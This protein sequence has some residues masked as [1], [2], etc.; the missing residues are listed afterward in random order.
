MKDIARN[1]PGPSAN[2]VVVNKVLVVTIWVW[3]ARKWTWSLHL[4]IWSHKHTYDIPKDL[5]TLSHTHIHT[6]V[7]H[8]WTHIHEPHIKRFTH[9]HLQTY[10]EVD[11]C[12]QKQVCLHI[13]HI[14]MKHIPNDLHTSANMQRC[15]HAFTHIW[16]HLHMYCILKDLCINL[17][18]PYT[19]IH[20]HTHMCYT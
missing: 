14:Y 17:H 9:T 11:T 6:C 16:A 8:I 2:C 18:T 13:E 12:I 10:T 3:L 4:H 20:T 19:C 5:H 7:L 1:M 15:T